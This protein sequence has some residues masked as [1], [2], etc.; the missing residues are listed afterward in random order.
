MRVV[1]SSPRARRRLTRLGILVVAGGVVAGIVLLIPNPKAPNPAPAKNAPPAQAVSHSTY[2]SPAERHAID[3][4]LRKFV[5]AAIARRSPSTAWRLAGP[6]LKGGSTL[7]QWRHGTSPIPYFPASATNFSWRTIDSSAGSVDF[8]LLVHP[9]AGSKQTSSWVFS[10]QM[11]KRGG[12]WLVNGMYTTAILARPTKSGRHEIGPADFAA[13]GASSSSQSG[14]P[15]TGGAALGKPWLFAVGG[16]VLLVLLVPL[17]LG[18]AS[19]VRSRRAR[20]LYGRSE[21]QSLPPLPRS[22]QRPGDPAGS[23]GVS[24]Q[25]H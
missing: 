10:G 25:R 21:P 2:V 19:V 17:G 13:G 22:A 12:H 9:R 4:T 14:P 3:A 1:P 8:S 5:P 20:K 24:A 23:G 18:V 7:Q 6:E 16:V 11:V 15:T